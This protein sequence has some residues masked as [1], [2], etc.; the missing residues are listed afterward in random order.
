[1]FCTGFLSGSAFSRLYR[2]VSLVWRCQ[3]GLAPAY[4]R[5]LCRS[6]SG[7]Q[8]SRSLRSAEMGVLL[9]PFAR[10]ASMQNRAFGRALG[11]GMISLRSCACSLDCAPIHF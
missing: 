7:Y 11:F 5:D 3:L 9:V 2:V 1:M 8:V 4:L 10:T 6:V